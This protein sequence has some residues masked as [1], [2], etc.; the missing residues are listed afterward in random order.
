MAEALTVLGG[1]KALRENDQIPIV[2]DDQVIK[3]KKKST[4]FI[5]LKKNRNQ[6]ANDKEN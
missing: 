1:V 3:L 2:Y 6:G 4:D 5:Q